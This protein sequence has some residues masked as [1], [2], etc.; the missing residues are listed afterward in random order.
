MAH[1]LNCPILVVV[2]IPLRIP[3]F[4]FGSWSGF[5]A[6][7]EW[8]ICCSWDI[9]PQ[10]KITRIS[11]QLQLSASAKFV[12]FSPISHWKHPLKFPVSASYHTEIQS[13]AANRTSHAFVQRFTKIRWQLFWLVLITDRQTHPQS[14]NITSLAEIADCEIT[15]YF[16]RKRAAARTGHGHSVRWSTDISWPVTV[17]R[18]NAVLEWN[19]GLRVCDTDWDQDGRRR[20]RAIPQIWTIWRV[21]SFLSLSGICRPTAALTAGMIY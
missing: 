12:E 10:I 19:A 18:E 15:T 7:I 8:F 9:P 6:K 16:E 4:G 14:Q 17:E 5:S 3:R 21:H 2:K 1:S 13:A 20:S 11:W